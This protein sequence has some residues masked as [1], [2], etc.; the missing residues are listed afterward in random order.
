VGEIEK[1]T[2]YRS[3]SAAGRV[4]AGAA[5]V[6][7]LVD[8]ITAEAAAMQGMAEQMPAMSAEAVIKILTT[9]CDAQMDLIAEKNRTI[10]LQAALIE[11]TDRI[12]LEKIQPGDLDRLDTILFALQSDPRP[13]WG[14]CIES[15]ERVLKN[16][17]EA[18]T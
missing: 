12:P 9:R 11:T 14:A 5:E 18:G 8:M 10:S 3:H 7:V 6:G 2:Q 15:L 16:V 1:N 4:G 13:I 17:R